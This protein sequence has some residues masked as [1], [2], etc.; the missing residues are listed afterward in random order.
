MPE[1]STISVLIMLIAVIAIV[2][3]G[4][5]SADTSKPTAQPVNQTGCNGLEKPTTMP[6]VENIPVVHI[7]GDGCRTSGSYTLDKPFYIVKV[8]YD[9]EKG[10]PINVSFSSEYDIENAKV[11]AYADGDEWSQVIQFVKP[12]E[13][14][15][16]R[17]YSLTV[18]PAV[19]ASWRVEVYEPEPLENAVSPP[20]TV[21]GTGRQVMPLLELK[22]GVAM[23]NITYTHP[24]EE[25]S[26][27]KL[28]TYNA[29]DGTIPFYKRESAYFE[30]TENYNGTVLIGV[31]NDGIYQ[32]DVAGSPDSTWIISV[33]Q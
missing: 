3:S 23:I 7:K 30:G 33:S 22:K 19:P 20:I 16:S 1:R 32:F 15:D 18:T 17:S 9:A 31:I 6:P 5:T 2:T 10:T 26:F 11:V 24:P 28:L 14:T 27:F 12:A 4:C 13:D 8:W 21:T 29:T 25:Y